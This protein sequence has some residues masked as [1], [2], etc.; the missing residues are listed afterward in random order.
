MPLPRE[1]RKNFAARKTPLGRLLSSG[2]NPALP[3]IGF[4]R[5]PKSLVNILGRNHVL[6]H[7][8]FDQHGSGEDRLLHLAFECL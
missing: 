7:L 5:T 2:I 3:I 8:L 4:D 6:F 1:F